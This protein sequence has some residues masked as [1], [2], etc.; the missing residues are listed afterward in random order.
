MKICLLYT[1]FANIQDA[2]EIT[3]QLISERLAGCVN[4][5][6]GMESTYL[7]QGKLEHSQE[8]A[9]LIK[10]TGSLAPQLKT[11]LNE[12]HPYEVPCIIEIAAGDTNP[13]YLSWLHNIT[14][15]SD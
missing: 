14:Q 7:W 8:I 3:N 13:A 4:L 11:R 2:R 6:G 15:R 12:L 9:A 5:L 10:T 1:S